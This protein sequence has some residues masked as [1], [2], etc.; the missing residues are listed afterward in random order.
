[1]HPTTAQAFP[2]WELDQPERHRSPRSA[3]V[4]LKIPTGSG[5]LAIQ[6]FASFNP[7]APVEYALTAIS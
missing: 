6:T 2:A 3:F 4:A 7:P 1:M 5:S